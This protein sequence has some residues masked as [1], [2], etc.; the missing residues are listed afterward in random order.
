[1]SRDA[2]FTHAHMTR[3]DWPMP[4]AR[5]R[6]W[7]LL[8]DTRRLPGWYGEGVI[9]GRVGGKPGALQAHTC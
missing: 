8:T 2:Q 4:A 1:M 3:F 5:E 7:E 6:V 9:E